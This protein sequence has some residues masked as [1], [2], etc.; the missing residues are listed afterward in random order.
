MRL[1]RKHVV[2]AGSLAI[3]V[4]FVYFTRIVTPFQAERLAIHDG[5]IGGTGEDPYRFRVLV[6]FL[7]EAIRRAF[8]AAGQ[9]AG[10]AFN[11]ASFVTDI[12]MLFGLFVSAAALLRRFHDDR[13]TLIGL[14]VMGAFIHTM[15]QNHFYS[16]WTIA[17]AALFNLFLLRFDAPGPSAWR[18]A[19]IM[20][21]LTAVATINRETGVAMPA[22]LALAAVSAWLKGERE[23]LRFLLPAAATAGL[24]WAL[25]FA[26]LRLAIGPGQPVIALGDV[27]AENLSAS[28][29]GKTYMNLFLVFTMLWVFVP[30]GFARAA[31]RARRYLMLGLCC[32]LPLI[33]VFA[34]WYEVRLYMPIYALLTSMLVSGL[35]FTEPERQA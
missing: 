27:W 12:A 4:A 7:I 8:E 20:G 5:V 19:A 13:G 29:L 28:G 33:A 32:Y 6:P 35:D 25:V 10:Q 15:L 17:E 31:P 18:L 14:L 3:V 9:S 21:G 26:G 23:Q 1:D 22:F 16:P 11:S 2:V 34:I 24:A 30:S